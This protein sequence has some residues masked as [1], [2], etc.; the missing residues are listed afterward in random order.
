MNE[1]S[2]AEQRAAVRAEIHLQRDKLAQRLSILGGTPGGYPRSVTMRLLM[3]RPELVAKLAALVVGPRI[4]G[5]V[6]AG[7]ALVQ[8]LRPGSVR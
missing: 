8:A 1:P 4:A 7:L 5:Q 3:Q 6:S 2:L